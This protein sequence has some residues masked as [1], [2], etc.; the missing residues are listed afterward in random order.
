MF[1]I[2]RKNSL[3]AKMSKC[4][5]EKKQ[6]QFLGHIIAG[7]GIRANPDKVDAMMRWQIPTTIK[8]LRGFLGLTGY[9]RRFIRQYAQ[10][11]QPM[12]E[13]LKKNEFKWGEKATNSFN[14]LKKAM[15][16]APVLSY[17]NFSNLFVVETDA[18]NTGIGA[19]L[20]QDGH[21]MAYY[22]SKLSGKRKLANLHMQ[23]NY[24]R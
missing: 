20:M 23:E 14:A 1:E 4:S 16:E 12:T 15:L 8:Q 10:I 17:P 18:S 6:L 3:A 5:F 11:A 19:V 24:L 21:P 2:L 22:S 13:L 9:Y 7:D